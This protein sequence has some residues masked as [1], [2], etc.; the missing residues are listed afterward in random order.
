MKSRLIKVFASLV[1]VVL[2]VFLVVPNFSHI[3][4]AEETKNVTYKNW[5]SFLY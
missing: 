3:S 2:A 1:L 5:Q 4:A